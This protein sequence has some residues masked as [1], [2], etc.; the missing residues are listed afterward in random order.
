MNF[1]Q[2]IVDYICDTQ[3]ADLSDVAVDTVGKMLLAD[4]GTI[5]AGANADGCL[6]LLEFYRTAGGNPEAT[7]LVHGD[8]LPA[9]NAA[10][11]N[12][13]MSRA[14]DFCDA[15]APGPHIGSSIIPAALA[16][17]ELRG[18]CDG[19]EFLTALTIGAEIAARMNLSESAYDGFDPTGICVPF[20]ATAVACRLLGLNKSQTWN[21]LGLIFNCCGGSF[22][23]HI[24][25]SLCV[26]LNQGRLTYD[27]ISSARLALSGI[28]GPENFLSGIYGY[29]HIYGKGQF[30]GADIVRELGSSSRLQEIAFK[31]YPSCAMTL[32]PTDM[33]L[34]MLREYKLDPADISAVKFTL[35]PYGHRLVGHDFKIGKNP[36]VDGQFSAQYCV[37][38][39]LLRGSA[40]LRHFTAES[41]SDPEIKKFISMISVEPD[42]ALDERG[43][44]AMDMEITTRKE[45]VFRNGIDV[46]PGF[47]GNSLTEDDHLQRFMDCIDYASARFSNERVETVLSF[48][49]GVEQITDVRGLIYLLIDTKNSRELI[50]NEGLSE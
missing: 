50:Q 19:E 36:T 31:K 22:Q 14:L 29:L 40:K 26:R 5:I 3:F 43:H 6:E 7:V 13:M 1:E 46:A 49:D 42:P 47:P 11:V 2:Q 8:K 45:E 41:V 25:G 33:T 35:P 24:D 17:S 16:C 39:V 27:A 12:A 15:I 20:G 34:N 30:S 32:G 38:N 9:Q 44:T 28:T 18:G 4:I 48:I 23:S 37:A 10:M 21:A